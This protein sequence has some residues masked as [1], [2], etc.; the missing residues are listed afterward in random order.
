L[1]SLSKKIAGNRIG[2]IQSDAS[3]REKLRRRAAIGLHSTED[4]ARRF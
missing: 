3:G 4:A 1:L 2:T